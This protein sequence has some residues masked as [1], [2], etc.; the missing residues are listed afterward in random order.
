MLAKYHVQFSIPLEHRGL[1]NDFRADDPV[2][3]EGFISALLLGG[4]KIN[5]ISH[6]GV[7]L[8]QS[9]FDSAILLGA[10]TAMI[11]LLTTALDIDEAKM[12]HRYGALFD[13]K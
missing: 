6:Q 7:P 11:K 9:E 3:L 13:K 12:R 8:P 2:E 5:S 4:Y 1:A 10:K